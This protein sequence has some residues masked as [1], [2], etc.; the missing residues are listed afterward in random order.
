MLPGDA[1]AGVRDELVGALRSIDDGA[2]STM[3]PACPA[4]TVREVAAHVCGLNAELLANVP[5]P[6]G[7]DTATSRQ[8]ADR[9]SASLSD[10]LD[11]WESMAPAIGN[12]FA[13]EP[14]RATA[15][16]ADLVVHAHD[17]KPA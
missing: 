10:V 11:E 8:V 9:S 13:A 4:W 1:Y 17:L 3:V 12:R 16:L 7:S 2:A 14:D 5:G 15:L 6:L